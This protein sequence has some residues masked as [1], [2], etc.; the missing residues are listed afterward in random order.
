MIMTNKS[1]S[2][3]LKFGSS[4]LRDEHDLSRAV[5]EIS[6]G[7]RLGSKVFAVVSALGDT[8]DQLMQLA[9]NICSDPE[10]SALATL[11]AT[12]ETASSALLGLALAD[13][14]IPSRVLDPAQACLRTAG[15]RLDADLI[16]IDARRLL[17]ESRHA[18]V[19]LPGFV[20]RDETGSTT[21]LGRGGSDLTALFLAHRL[22]GHCVLLKDVD[23]LYTS[24]PN[25]PSSGASRFA[26]VSYKTAARVAG[27]VVQVKAVHFAESEQQSFTIT[28][29]GSATGTEVGPFNDCLYPAPATHL[30]EVCC[31]I[32]ELEECVA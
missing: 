22:N 5:W 28:S 24:D 13:A 20:G 15:P 10:Q 14:G 31:E 3:V 4:V 9:K 29:I 17:A 7:R 6:R 11:L 18:V 21:L 2:V 16:S 1:Q 8:T 30:S 19:V 26:Q 23:G 25:S 27:S 32:E 12:G